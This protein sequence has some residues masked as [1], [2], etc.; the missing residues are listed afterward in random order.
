MGVERHQ[1]GG[2]IHRYCAHVITK[3]PF[4]IT[5]DIYTKE[6]RLILTRAQAL[7]LFRRSAFL[8]GNRRFSSNCAS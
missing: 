1:D 5:N 3:D 4:V 8:N 7:R 2:E 6:D